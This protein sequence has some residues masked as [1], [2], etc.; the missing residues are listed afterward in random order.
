MML[1]TI[2]VQASADLGLIDDTSISDSPG[3]GKLDIRTLTLFR[4]NRHWWCSN[5]KHCQGTVICKSY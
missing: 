5:N 3:S 2:W 4:Q 1:K